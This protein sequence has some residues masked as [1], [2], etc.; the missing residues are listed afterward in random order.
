[1]NS[2]AKGARA[3]REMA[4]EWVR[5]FGGQARR[6][7]Q[8]A[9]GTDSP[10]VIS[11]HGNL[12]LEVKRVEAGNPYTWMD[13]AVR[14]AGDKVPVVLHRRNGRDW[15]L[16]VRLDDGP[17]LAQEI[18]ATAE[19]VGRPEIPTPVPGQGVPTP[20]QSDGRDAGLLAV[21]RRGRTRDHR[22]AEY[23]G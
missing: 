7:Q 6:G 22:A 9:G 10:D 13:Q 2:R 19:V 16:I 20:G 12:H 15:L 4:K 1:V 3:E 5:V 23:P 14:D 21:Q 8:F 17:R 11:S 18:A